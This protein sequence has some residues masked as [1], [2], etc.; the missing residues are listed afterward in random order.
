MLHCFVLQGYVLDDDM[1][2]SDVPAALR[3][4]HRFQHNFSVSGSRGRGQT[5]VGASKTAASL[6]H[7]LVDASPCLEGN[8]LAH[9]LDYRAFSQGWQEDAARSVAGG[10]NACFCHLV[11]TGQV[12]CVWQC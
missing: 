2:D 12:A 10:A 3:E 9:M 4:F 11:T 7:F 5:R 6:S 8:P 1:Y